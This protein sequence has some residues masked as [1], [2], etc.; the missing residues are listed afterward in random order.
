M[1]YFIQ[2]QYDSRPIIIYWLEEPFCHDPKQYHA[3]DYYDSVVQ[4]VGRKKSHLVTIG[5]VTVERPSGAP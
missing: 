1:S 2:Q 4:H 5:V 3:A